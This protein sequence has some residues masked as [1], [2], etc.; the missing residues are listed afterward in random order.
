[1]W[2][3]FH[4]FLWGR[5]RIYSECPDESHRK[6]SASEKKFQVSKTS[7]LMSDHS[8]DP[9]YSGSCDFC[10]SARTGTDP[11]GDSERYSRISEPDPEAGRSV[12][13]PVSGD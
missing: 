4:H 8:S 11:D 1:M 3:S 6:A 10:S 12:V 2:E 9:W 13:C 7:Q 5:D